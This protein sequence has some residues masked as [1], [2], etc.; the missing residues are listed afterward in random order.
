MM[1]PLML[2]TANAFAQPSPP[3]FEGLRGRV[4]DG[5]TL[6]IT[7]VDGRTFVGRVSRVSPEALTIDTRAGEE[8]LTPSDAE[9]IVRRDS[10][11]NGLLWGLLGG[12]VASEM[13]LRSACGPRGYDHECRVN[14]GL[15][16]VPIGLGAGIGVGLL[17][18][19]GVKRTVFSAPGARV[20]VAPVIGRKAVG[21]SAQ[22]S[23]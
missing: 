18:D 20:S 14:A 10:L 2:L 13:M 1:V 19:S 5:D 4:R 9:R 8:T 23:F 6:E 7:R 22:L 16:L 3:S 17:A 21:V 12:L 15:L 11:D